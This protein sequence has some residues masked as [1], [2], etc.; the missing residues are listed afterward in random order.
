LNSSYL[1]ERHSILFFIRSYF[2]DAAILNSKSACNELLS[3]TDRLSKTLKTIFFLSASNLKDFEYEHQKITPHQNY[4]KNITGWKQKQTKQ[5]KL[6]L[7]L[8]NYLPMFF[9]QIFGL[10]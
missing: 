5:H 1:Q 3:I 2:L 7:W 6:K 10:N 8:V 4:Y 9:I